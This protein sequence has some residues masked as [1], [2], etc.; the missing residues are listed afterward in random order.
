MALNFPSNPQMSDTYLTWEWDGTSWNSV[1]S[2]GGSGNIGDYLTPDGTAT[3]TNKTISYA[4]NTLTGVQPTLVSGTSIK[5]INGTSILGSGDISITAGAP[6]LTETSTST[7]TNK[8]ISYA[9]NTLTGV[10]PTLVSGTSI[11][12]INGT[13]ILGSGDISISSG[14]L[15]ETST[16]TLTNKTLSG[17][18]INDGYTEEVYTVSGT[19]PSLSPNNGSIQVWTLENNSTPSQGTWSQGQSIT[20]MIDDGSNYTIS[21]SSLGVSWKTNLGIA[22]T[23]NTTGYTVIALWKVG[24]T[25]FG[26]RVGDA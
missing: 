13:S 5:T 14:T 16:S 18:V 19:T 8:T 25:I 2:S 1:A 23:L 7:L 11:K 15:T 6:T 24:S 12:T 22:P 21:W 10:Q 20:L 3:L 26:A 9:N 4:N 17:A